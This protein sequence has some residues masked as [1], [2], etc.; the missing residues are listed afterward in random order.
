MIDAAIEEGLVDQRIP[1]LALALNYED[2]SLGQAR[3]LAK[4]PWPE[5]VGY[6]CDEPGIERGPEVR[7]VAECWWSRGVR[8]GVAIEGENA[9]V[10]GDPL[11]VW[12]VYM[13][14]LTPD[15]I[16]T[17]RLTGKELWVYNCGVRAGNAAMMR[18]YT[19][20]YTWAV[21]AKCCLTWALFH[22]RESRIQPDG[23]WNV[24]R[25]HEVGAADSQGHLLPSVA[26]EGMADGIVD[27]RLLQTLA[28]KNTMEGNAYLAELRKKVPDLYAPVGMRYADG[29]YPW[30]GPDLAKPPLDCR[31]IRSDVLKLLEDA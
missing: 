6:N 9:L 7:H 24:L 27:N 4:H 29:A 25:V 23:T 18:Y 30:D 13:D 3:A 21:G 16:K 22:L 10:I 19:G 31:E 28:R 8:N 12:V 2:D 14:S 20:V 26:L 1:L 5:I 17:A 15:V 11:Q